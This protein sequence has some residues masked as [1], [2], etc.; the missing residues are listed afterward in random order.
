MALLD[1]TRSES[2][3]ARCAILLA[4]LSTKDQYSRVMSA[5]SVSI[6]LVEQI[7]TMKRIPRQIYVRQMPS[8]SPV[9]TVYG[10]WLRRIEPPGHDSSKITILSKTMTTHADGV[11]LSHGQHGTA[12]VVSIRPTETTSGMWG[13]WSRVRWIKVGFDSEFNPR[14]FL[15]N[16]YPSTFSCILRP[17]GERFK[18]PATLAQISRTNSLLFNHWINRDPYASRLESGTE[19]DF[20]FSSYILEVDKNAGCD[21]TLND[22]NLRIRFKLLPDPS[23][24]YDID[25]AL[26]GKER[27]I[28]TVDIIEIGGPS[29]EYAHKEWK[30]EETFLSGAVICYFFAWWVLCRV[31]YEA[32]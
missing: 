4:S 5:E 23:P 22:L 7:E 8:E 20:R 21:Y 11:F 30:Y 27:R 3:D 31:L 19:R 16:N 1:C 14:I 6:L 12:G 28:W 25:Q 17:N 2:P 18:Q 15:A 26:S 29:P 24:T 13:M 32:F 10:F 9:N